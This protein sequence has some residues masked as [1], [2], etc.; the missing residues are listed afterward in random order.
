MQRPSPSLQSMDFGAG[1]AEPRSPWGLSTSTEKER[2]LT[3]VSLENY[4]KAIY[5]LQ[6]G[7]EERV[8]TKSLAQALQI[9]LPSVTGMLKSLSDEG[10]LDY[11]PYRG[12]ILTEAGQSIAL[13]IVRHHRLIETFLVDSLGY[14]WDEVHQEAEVLEHAVSDKLASRIERYLGYPKF[15]PHGDPIPDASG[16]IADEATTN[17]VR[18]KANTRVTIVRVHDQS[19]EFLRYLGG[20]GLTPD[21]GATVLEQMPFDGPIRVQCGDR[22]ATLSRSQAGRISV[23]VEP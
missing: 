2:Y 20:L 13:R 14:S 11:Q 18:V 15:D 16:T 1:R 5:H 4:L 21:A 17:L 19:P 6:G 8:K 22:E 10:L 12:V 3:Q 7:K 9:S 23:R